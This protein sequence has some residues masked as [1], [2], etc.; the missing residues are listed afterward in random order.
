MN[1]RSTPIHMGRGPALLLQHCAVLAGGD[2]ARLPAFHRLEQA[3]GGDLA[4]FLV[5]ALA[6]R[7]RRSERVELAA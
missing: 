7:T 3:V 5:V 6:P 2:D 1:D 4:R